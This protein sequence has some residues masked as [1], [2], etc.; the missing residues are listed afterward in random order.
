MQAVRRNYLKDFKSS[1]INFEENTHAINIKYERYAGLE[2][3][4]QCLRQHSKTKF[5]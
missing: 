4:V 3:I 5:Y 1:N 2:I